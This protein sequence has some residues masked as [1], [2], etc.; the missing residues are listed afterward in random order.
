MLMCVGGQRFEEGAKGLEQ[1][2]EEDVD[3]QGEVGGNG[4]GAGRT[5]EH[6]TGVRV[7]GHRKTSDA[8]V[9]E[10][11]TAGK[12]A[13]ILEEGATDAA[14]EVVDELGAEVAAETRFGERN[15]RQA[16][17]TDGLDRPDGASTRCEDGLCSG[18]GGSSNGSNSSCRRRGS[19]RRRRGNSG[20]GSGV[21]MLV[22]RRW[23]ENCSTW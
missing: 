10:T 19:R 1:A 15:C 17:A 11:M 3:R 13:W 22:R 4:H 18:S 2:N 21:L 9:A 6:L 16:R 20:R 5:E 7:E 23:T 12:V 14:L 8:V